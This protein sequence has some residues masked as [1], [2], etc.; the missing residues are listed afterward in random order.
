MTVE[1]PSGSDRFDGA[2]AGEPPATRP[3]QPFQGPEKSDILRDRPPLVVTPDLEE[4]APP[5]KHNAGIHSSNEDDRDDHGIG[6]DE[7]QRPTLQGHTSGAAHNV[8]IRQRALDAV[9]RL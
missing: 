1:L 6:R 5:A 2:E 9:E 8:L 7:P 4:I 3:T